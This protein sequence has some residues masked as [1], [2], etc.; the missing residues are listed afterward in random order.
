MQGV[1]D[2]FG[3]QC[4]LNNEV[5][6]WHITQQTL[7]IFWQSSSKALNGDSV[8]ISASILSFSLRPITF[9]T[10]NNRECHVRGWEPVP[11]AL[12]DHRARSSNAHPSTLCSL[13]LIVLEMA[14]STPKTCPTSSHFAAMVGTTSLRMSNR[15][16]LAP[17]NHQADKQ[18]PQCY[19]CVLPSISTTF[20]CETADQC[21]LSVFVDH[22]E[23]TTFHLA[24]Y[25]SNVTTK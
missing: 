11:A 9:S 4:L 13:R 20:K 6:A 7:T 16:G 5:V 2:K 22:K 19:N 8:C 15:D 12:C 24:S 23:N 14:R 17:T 25:D 18:S 1:A 3:K 21:V 10:A